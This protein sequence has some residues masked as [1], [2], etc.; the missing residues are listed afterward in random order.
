MVITTPFTPSHDLLPLSHLLLSQD[1]HSTSPPQGNLFSPFT[2]LFLTE[3]FTHPPRADIISV[4]TAGGGTVL[5]ASE[6]DASGATTNQ[7]TGLGRITA[8]KESPAGRGS[9]GNRLLVVFADVPAGREWSEEEAR[10]RE[11]RK[12]R[13]GERAKEVGAVASVSHNWVLDS[14]A[15]YRIKP[16]TY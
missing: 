3:G 9:G 5:P 16:L 15:A 12:Q 6:S 7:G 4:F 8:R 10:G 2:A 13:A 11:E 14:A 1:P